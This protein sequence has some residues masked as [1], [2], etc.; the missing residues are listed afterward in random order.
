MPPKYGAAATA[1][2]IGAAA[3]SKP[4]RLELDGKKWLV[5]YFKGNPSIE[6]SETENNHSIYVYR[7]E[8]STI[9]VK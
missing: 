7:C 6:I 5:E 2:T 8:G 9:I 3:V 1:A 4:S